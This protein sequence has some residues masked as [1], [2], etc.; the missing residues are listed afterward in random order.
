[1]EEDPDQ[2]L[3][4]TPDSPLKSEELP[5]EYLGN[6]KLRDGRTYKIA[7]RN[8][9]AGHDFA[10]YDPAQ[11]EGLPPGLKATCTKCEDIFK[12]DL[13][14]MCERHALTPS[15]KEKTIKILK[16]CKK[17]ITDEIDRRLHEMYGVKYH[18]NIKHSGKNFPLPDDVSKWEKPT[19]YELASKERAFASTANLGFT[20]ER[21]KKLGFDTEIEW[22]HLNAIWYLNSRRDKCLD[23]IQKIKP[24]RGR[25]KHT[26]KASSI[27]EEEWKGK[28]QEELLK[29]QEEQRKR[30]E[31]IISQQSKTSSKSNTKLFKTKAEKEAEKAAKKA[32]RTRRKLEAATRKK[33]EQKASDKTVTASAKSVTASAT[34]TTLKRAK[35][36]E[37]KNPRKTQR[38]P[39]SFKRSAS[40]RPKTHRR[41]VKSKGG[42]K[43]RRH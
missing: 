32:E 19:A 30:L 5:D 26:K 11:D 41:T 27:Q 43:K 34:T 9:L 22:N 4:I 37:S 16:K 18:W 23:A 21:M 35:S 15:D 3:P 13:S 33:P 20:K 39:V 10:V 38:K 24:C 28:T 42:G 31:E 40:V 17:K 6:K 12:G 8:K 25:G 1:M 36:A 2:I 29:D 7:A 14:A